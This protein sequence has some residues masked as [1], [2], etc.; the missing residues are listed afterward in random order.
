[1]TLDADEASAAL[2]EIESIARRVKQSSIYRAYSL[3]LIGW[4]ALVAIGNLAE[5][6]AGHWAGGVW[7][8]LNLLGVALLG[9]AM[10]IFVLGRTRQGDFAPIR[11]L[12]A[13]ALFFAFGFVWSLL[14]GK[15]GPRE[16][17][18]FWPS[19]FLFGY[20]L[21]GLFFGRAFTVLGIGLTASIL[22]GY[23]WVGAG[24][25]LYLALVNGGGLMLCGYW[26]RRA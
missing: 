19:L 5:L 26:M 12:A 11:T 13:F 15:M 21:A 1:L 2:A 6:F 4:G 3:T 9:V 10:T 8:A 23:E 24:Y 20:A 18:A 16:M 17:D 7:I 14:L 22:A 25:G